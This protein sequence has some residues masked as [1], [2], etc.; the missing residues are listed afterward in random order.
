MNIEIDL[1]DPKPI[2]A[3]LIEQIKQAVANDKIA[4]NDP[5]P[6]IRQLANDL[7]V[8]SKTISKAYKLLERDAVI[9][10]KGYRG[11]FVHPDAKANCQID[12]KEWVTSQFEEL[13]TRLKEAG[14]TDSEMR[15]TFNDVLTNN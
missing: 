6:S 4:P 12:L 14:V 9:Q 11:T 8:N 13:I 2:F 7:E 10:S 3:Q 1:D 5:L 15:L